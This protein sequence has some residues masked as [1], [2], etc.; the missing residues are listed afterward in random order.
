MA[1][2]VQVAK[3]LVEI[4]DRYE[5]RF[6]I[7]E[8]DAFLNMLEGPSWYALNVKKRRGYGFYPEKDVNW[9][10]YLMWDQWKYGYPIQLVYKYINDAETDD[11]F[12]RRLKQREGD[13]DT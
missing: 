4:T 9:C 1:K 7:N 6:V 8:D 3:V 10:E 12:E 13:N 5:N 11:E 2:R